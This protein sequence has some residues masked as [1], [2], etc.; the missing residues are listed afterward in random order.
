M[1]L[2][3]ELPMGV[4]RRIESAKQ[5]GRNV[6]PKVKIRNIISVIVVLFCVPVIYTCYVLGYDF[7]MWFF[8]LNVISISWL[9][10]EDI[11]A[12]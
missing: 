3:K 6:K 8:I 12:R 2:I 5:M 1:R 11:Y 4:H 7:R 10:I 9:T